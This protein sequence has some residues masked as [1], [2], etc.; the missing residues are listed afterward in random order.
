MSDRVIAI[1]RV[2]SHEIDKVKGDKARL[3]RAELADVTLLIPC[4]KVLAG[5]GYKKQRYEEKPLLLNYG[6]VSIPLD[7]AR[8]KE[9]LIEICR[10]TRSVSSFVY[11]REIDIEEEKKEAEEKGI[12]IKPILVEQISS[13]EAARL[14]AIAANIQVFEGTGPLTVGSIV[15]LQS[16]PF[17]NMSGKIVSKNDHEIGVKLLDTGF[18]VKIQPEQ[19]YY[20]NS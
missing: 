20:K 18:V 14:E 4:V 11:R 1:V 5:V 10:L 19:L 2:D 15:L 12:E 3:A 16:Y 9:I 17:A 13:K 6:F 7:Y 8:D